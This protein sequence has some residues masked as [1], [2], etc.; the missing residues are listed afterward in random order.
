MQWLVGVIRH[1][2]PHAIRHIDAL[3]LQRGSWVGDEP[4]PL[5][6]RFQAWSVT[7]DFYDIRLYEF[8]PFGNQKPLEAAVRRLQARSRRPTKTKL[9]NA[10]FLP[11]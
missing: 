8:L 2:Y 11:A 9:G 1:D 4:G 6:C 3:S 5:R 7:Q 10:G